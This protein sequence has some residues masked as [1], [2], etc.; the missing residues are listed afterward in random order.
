[1]GVQGLSTQIQGHFHRDVTLLPGH[2]ANDDF[3]SKCT[4]AGVILPPACPAS[5]DASIHFQTP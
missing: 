1:M 2:E 3:I 4:A 5:A